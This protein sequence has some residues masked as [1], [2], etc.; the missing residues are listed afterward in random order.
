MVNET[1]P[2]FVTFLAEHLGAQQQRVPSLGRGFAGHF[3]YGAAGGISEPVL[4]C[5]RSW[6]S[7]GNM[8]N[9]TEETKTF[10]W[11]KRF[12]LFVFKSKY[13][14]LVNV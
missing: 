11:S 12:G 3:Y 10:P 7:L 2:R 6:F 13:F 1:F 5:V 8:M 14:L 4:W 9:L